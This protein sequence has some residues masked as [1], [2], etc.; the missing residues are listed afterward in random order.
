VG[1]RHRVSGIGHRGSG[2]VARWIHRVNRCS[3]RRGHDVPGFASIRHV[4]WRKHRAI[5][6]RSLRFRVTAVDA[7]ACQ[8]DGTGL[9]PRERDRLAS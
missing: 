4:Q 6:D 7:V 2:Q 9:L 1:Q 5:F 8:G 3:R